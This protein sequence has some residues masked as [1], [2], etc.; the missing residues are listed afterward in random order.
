MRITL[1]LPEAFAAQ[2]I[3]AGKDPAREALEAL[4]VE[5]YRTR[6]LNE[7]QVPLMLGFGTRMKVHAL[8]AAHG[9]PLNYT[10]ENLDEDIQAASSLHDEWL[11]QTAQ[12]K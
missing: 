10:M 11:S 6:R 5:G 1:D 2:I 4:A 7:S 8:L 9:V 12:P 3:A